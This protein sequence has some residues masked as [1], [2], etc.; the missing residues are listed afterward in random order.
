[1]GQCGAFWLQETVNLKDPFYELDVSIWRVA[2]GREVLRG[3]DFR[4][5]PVAVG[6]EH[7]C[8]WLRTG[9]YPVCVSSAFYIW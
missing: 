9:F 6:V 8:R 4:F 3:G 2:L 5:G 7:L 1:M